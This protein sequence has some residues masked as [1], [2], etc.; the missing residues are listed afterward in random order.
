LIANGVPYVI[1]NGFS[2]YQRKEIIDVISYIRL[3]L[4]KNDDTSFRRVINTPS[5]Y[6]GKVFMSKIDACR[7]SHFDALDRIVLKPFEK[8]NVDEFEDL[9]NRIRQMIV[10]KKVNGSV[11]IAFIL[12]YGR[13]EDEIKRSTS[14]DNDLDRMENL[15]ALGE[16]INQFET[17]DKFLNYIDMMASKRKDSIN[18]VQ[19]MSIHRS[20]G[21]EFPYVF[22]I[23]VSDGLL[24]HQRSIDNDNIEE[25][26]RLMYVGMTRAIDYLHISSIMNY[27]KKV[28][29]I[30]RFIKECG[31]EI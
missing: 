14:A 1:Q 19:L 24:P 30:S 7:C 26:R 21:L 5:R 6:L 25:E 27:N 8:R 11:L 10:G 31:F 12:K 9:V 23:G 15:V 16:M 20:K 3:A 28:L 13:Y 2:F 18:G 29:E 17:I 4:N 22:L